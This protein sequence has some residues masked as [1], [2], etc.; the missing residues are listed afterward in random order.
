MRSWDIHQYIN[1]IRSNW[2]MHL[3]GISFSIFSFEEAGCHECYI[4]EAVNPAST[5]G[6]GR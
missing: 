4:W 2:S 3:A 5:W 1:I 6:D